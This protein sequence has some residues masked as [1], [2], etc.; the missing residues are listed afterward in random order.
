MLTFPL[1]NA[2]LDLKGKPPE[3]L[4][5]GLLTIPPE[6]REIVTGQ[7]AKYPPEAHAPYEAG[8]LCFETV[9]WFF[10]DLA[11]PVVYRETPEGPDVLAVGREEVAAYNARVPHDVRPAA[12][13]TFRGFL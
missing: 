10:Y 9:G 3:E 7:L 6:V 11:V 12:V 13:K 8:R 5:H 2:A 4:P 1:H